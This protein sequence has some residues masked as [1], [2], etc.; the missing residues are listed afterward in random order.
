M[1]LIVMFDLPTT[2]YSSIKEY[3]C[4]RKFLLSEGFIMMQESVY[5]KLLLNGTDLQ[6]LY[7]RI[8]NNKPSKGVVQLLKITEKQFSSM[9]YLL[10]EK[11]DKIEDSDKRLIII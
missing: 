8:K 2:T 6:L 9:I 3:T 5:S 1:R 11:Q 7:E 4:F 10:G